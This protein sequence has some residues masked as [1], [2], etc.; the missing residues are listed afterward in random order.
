M[1]RKILVGAAT[2]LLALVLLGMTSAC[3]HRHSFAVTAEQKPTC[4]EGGSMEY[5]CR[6][7][8]QIFA[9][10]V[11]PTGHDYERTDQK[12]PTCA[13][14]GYKDFRCAACGDRTTESTAALGH[15]YAE[16]DCTLPKPC[17]RCGESV[18]RAHSGEGNF[19]AVCGVCTF[20][21]LTF[22]GEGEARMEHLTLPRGYYDITVTYTGDYACAL[23]L[24]DELLAHHTGEET[25][26][27]RLSPSDTLSYPD[28][29][30]TPISDGYL[31]IRTTGGA[32]T[33]TVTAVRA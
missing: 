1:N 17:T 4:T 9:E 16:G 10:T 29:V 24:G 20:E 5:E 25:F 8:G 2:A 23:Y 15:I 3:E 28:K 12:E 32:W 18:A 11:V 31:Q 6:T 33:L 27:C 26:T 30:G 21:T 22:T 13:A 14:V 19:C 7:C